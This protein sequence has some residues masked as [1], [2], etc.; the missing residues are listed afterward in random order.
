MSFSTQYDRLEISVS[1]ITE[2]TTNA[3][4]RRLHSQISLLEL[5]LLEYNNNS[6]VNK[7]RTDELLEKCAALA[8]SCKLRIIKGKKGIFWKIVNFLDDS[9]RILTSWSFLLNSSVFLV[10]FAKIVDIIYPTA[11]IYRWGKIFVGK[12]CIILSGVQ[13]D[14]EGL[15][16]DKFASPMS[17]VAFTHASTMD[18]FILAASTPVVTYTLSKKE[19]FLIPF[20]GWLLSA[21]GGVAIDRSNRKQATDALN[22]A[23]ETGRQT[24]KKHGTAV[25]ISP[26]GTRSKS[27]QLLAFKKGPFYLWEE[28]AGPVVPFII[29]GAYDLYGP[30]KNMSVSGRVVGR[31]LN[32]IQYNE[33]DEKAEPSKRRELMSRLLRRRMLES[34]L[35]SPIDVGDTG[36]IGYL[37]RWGNYSAIALCWSFNFTVGYL[38]KKYLDNNNITYKQAGWFGLGTTV[39]ISLGVYIYNVYIFGRGSENK[40]KTE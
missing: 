26:E 28:I 27:G 2:N 25:C 12:S 16:D 5:D 19:L 40:N 14:L 38:C 7:E 29:F 39:T 31:F 9:I 15:T 35:D 3:T 22:S 18:A 13:F 36:G 23:V 33:I 21:F 24:S 17:M 32:P 10:P 11:D 30:G 4:R 1:N 37:N 8:E 20:F 6:K 34:M